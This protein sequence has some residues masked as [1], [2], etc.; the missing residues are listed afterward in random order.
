MFIEI[1]DICDLPVMINP[2]SIAFVSMAGDNARIVLNSGDCI[3]TK[4][5]Y[6]TIKQVLKR[7]LR[8]RT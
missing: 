4:S 7:A 8:R 2:D 5:N 6:E 1:N 3:K